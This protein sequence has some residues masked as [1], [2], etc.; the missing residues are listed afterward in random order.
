MRNLVLFPGGRVLLPRQ[1]LRLRV[2]DAGLS[3]RLSEVDAFCSVFSPH[4]DELSPLGVVAEI[5]ARSAAPDDRLDV[6][7]IGGP[8]VRLGQAG[9][10]G[11]IEVEALP[12]LDGDGDLELLRSELQRGVQRFAAAAA[13]SG[14]PASISAVLHA[15][16]TIASY[17][18]ATLLPISHPERQELLEIETT[19][20]RLEQELRI[21]DG[22]TGILRHLLGLGRMGA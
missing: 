6:E 8:R 22:E 13:E 15:D 7:L 16:P 4:R 20:E 17:Q 21:V 5:T 18:A 3:G 12:E 1:R 9:L 2:H 14:R 11:T 19:T 10:D